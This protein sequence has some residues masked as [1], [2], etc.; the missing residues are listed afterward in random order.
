MKYTAKQ[1]EDAATACQVCACGRAGYNSTADSVVLATICDGDPASWDL[2]C[3]AFVR[4]P[5]SGGATFA[6]EWAEA[7]SWIRSGWRE[8]GDEL[9]FES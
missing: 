6:A 1:I 2:A 8:R 5:S 7:E 9:E 3:A 4:V